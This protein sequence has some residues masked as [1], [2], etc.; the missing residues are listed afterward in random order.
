LG[1]H[2]ALTRRPPPI[3]AEES[4]LALAAVVRKTRPATAVVQARVVERRAEAKVEPVRE[5]RAALEARKWRGKAKIHRCESLA[6]WPAA[7][8]APAAASAAPAALT[9][10]PAVEAERWPW[11]PR[12]RLRGLL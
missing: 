4:T 12:R 8:A 11:R 7:L 5:R 3:D 2:T 1:P 10:A 6:L 9:A